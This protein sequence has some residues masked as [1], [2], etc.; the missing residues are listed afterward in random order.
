MIEAV[1]FDFDGLILDTET[2]VYLSWKQVFQDNG[3][4]LTIEQWGE[5][6]GAK[7][8]S[9]NPPIMLEEQLDKRFDRERL[10]VTQRRLF[11]DLLREETVRPGVQALL[12][13]LADRDLKM[14]VASS[15]DREWVMSHLDRMG[16]WDYFDCVCCGDEVIEA[17]PAPWVYLAALADLRVKP[18][19]AIALED[20]PHGIQAAKAANVTCFAI[21]NTITQLLD[22]SAA[23]HEIESL[24]DHCLDDLVELIVRQRSS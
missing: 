23:D 13:E 15:S 5:C 4:D 7:Y 21:P 6:V 3:G 22:L 16:L 12:D 10:R 14:A 11:D 17:K 9:F 8:T 1:I 18:H 20:S 19:R 24:A 2:P